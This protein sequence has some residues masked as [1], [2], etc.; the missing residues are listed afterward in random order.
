MH[1]KRFIE[2]KPHMKLHSGGLS[3]H[4]SMDKTYALFEECYYF[5][6]ISKNMKKCVENYRIC[7]HAKGRSQNTRLQAPLPIL[8]VSWEDINMDFML[9]LLRTQ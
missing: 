3:G 7:Q 4:F 2:I 8:E 5:L 6:G 1:P 9:G